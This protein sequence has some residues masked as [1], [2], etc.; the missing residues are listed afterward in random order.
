MTLTDTHTPAQAAERRRIQGQIMQTVGE[1]LHYLNL[2][3]EIAGIENFMHEAPTTAQLR[4]M[5]DAAPAYMDRIRAEKTDLEY[6][7]VTSAA[8]ELAAL[9]DAIRDGLD[10]S[11]AELAAAQAKATAEAH[12]AELAEQGRKAREKKARELAKSQAAALDTVRK[13][14]PTMTNVDEQ[15]TA[16]LAAL[17]AVQAAVADYGTQV[18]AAHDTLTAGGVIAR[19]GL[20]HNPEG[21]DEDNHPGYGYV[22]VDGTFYAAS[23]RFAEVRRRIAAHPL[24]RTR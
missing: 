18:Q 23:D 15:V 14:P 2:A 1:R 12:G 20:G 8:D 24:I 10:V 22:K 17:D 6:V 7:P 4:E 16:A 19:T 3:Q 5:L 13:N 9:E 21:I 11:P